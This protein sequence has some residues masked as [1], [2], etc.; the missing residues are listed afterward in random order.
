MSNTADSLEDRLRRLTPPPLPGDLKR[1]VMAAAS[2]APRAPWGDRVWYSSAWRLAAVGTLLA[3]TVVDRWSGERFSFEADDP[4][5]FT[6][7]E[8]IAVADVG[9]E[10]GLPVE[11]VTHLA[12]RAQFV[13]F[14]ARES[15]DQSGAALR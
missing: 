2:L 10:I 6:A 13:R 4:A 1:R 5:P 9:R 8:R 15:A 11:T 3:V 14:T 7:A 12:A